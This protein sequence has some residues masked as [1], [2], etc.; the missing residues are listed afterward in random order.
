MATSIIESG[1]LERKEAH[2]RTLKAREDRL[3]KEAAERREAA[4]QKELMRQ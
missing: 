4:R 2:G 1:I 3:A